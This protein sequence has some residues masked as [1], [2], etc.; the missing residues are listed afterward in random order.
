[1]S[2]DRL[3][4]PDRAASL[5]SSLPSRHEDYERIT[6]SERVADAADDNN[7]IGEDLD[8][9]NMVDLD[10]I[11]YGHCSFTSGDVITPSAVRLYV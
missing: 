8:H 5:T 6:T 11:Q 1:M 4:S 3:P 7:I 2:E 9:W 10:Y